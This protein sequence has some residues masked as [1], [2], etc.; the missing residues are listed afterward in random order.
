MARGVSLVSM[1]ILATS[2]LLRCL[3]NIYQSLDRN[4]RFRTHSLNREKNEVVCKMFLLNSRLAHCLTGAK[5]TETSGTLLFPVNPL[6]LSPNFL[7][8]LA[9]SRQ[10]GYNFM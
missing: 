3:A 8:I 1:V 6:Q 4:F 2:S 9:Y 10:P 5:R 7:F